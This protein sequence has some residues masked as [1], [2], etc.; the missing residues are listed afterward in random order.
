MWF[1]TR[2]YLDS[3]WHRR[4]R[5]R[6]LSS[7]IEKLARIRYL[8]RCRFISVSIPSRFWLANLALW[9]LELLFN[10]STWISHREYGSSKVAKDTARNR[11]TVK[12]ARA[13]LLH[14]LQKISIDA[15][16]CILAEIAPCW[17]WGNQASAGGRHDNVDNTTEIARRITK[18]SSRSLL[19]VA[20]LSRQI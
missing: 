3:T 13:C 11:Y 19:H 9:L 1:V 20:Q 5:R 8:F 12:L 15:W 7:V 10:R 14:A 6:D 4:R 17:N 18:W 16:R 2:R